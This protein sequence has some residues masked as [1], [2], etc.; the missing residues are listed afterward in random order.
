MMHNN[1]KDRYRNNSIVGKYNYIFT[2]KLK[3][4]SN[5]RFA[6]TYLQYDKEID[7]ATATHD[8]EVD[9]I[10]SSYNM[11]MTYDYNERF[12]NKF[13][14]ANTYIRRIYGA[15]ENSGNAKQDNYYG[16]RYLL[17]YTGNYNFNLDNSI[18]FGIEREDDQMDIIKIYQEE[19]INTIS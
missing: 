19:K 17:S 18:V 12:S 11:S 15:T 7:T 1:E 14:L 8:E 2:D 4:Q 5:F 3:F 10:E 9:G 16:D 13:T 6:D